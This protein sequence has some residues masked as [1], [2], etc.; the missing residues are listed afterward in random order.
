MTQVN[1]VGSIGISE[2]VCYILAP[3]VFVKDIPSLRRNGFMPV[4]WLSILSM[5]GCCLASAYNNTAIPFFL[6]G[7]AITYSLFAL[8]VCIH[9]MLRSNLDGLKWIFLGI[10]ISRIINIFVFRQ[11]Y[12]LSALAGGVEDA[13]TASMIMAGPLFWLQRLGGFIVLPVKGWYFNTPIIY[14]V[15]APLIMTVFTILTTETGR[16]ALLYSLGGVVLI[17]IGRKS[18]QKMVTIQRNLLSWGFVAVLLVFCF[19]TA[20]KQLALSGYLNEKAQQKYEHQT[21]GKSG[22]KALLMG[23]RSELFMGIYA[24]TKNPFWGFGPWNSDENGYNLEFLAKYG[25]AE[26][27]EEYSKSRALMQK[28]GYLEQ[29]QSHSHIIGFWVRY[30]MLALP[31]WLYI[32]YCMYRHCRRNM[33]AIPQWYGYFALALP[34]MAWHIVFSP[35]GGRVEDCLFIVCLLLANAVRCGTIQLPIEMISEIKRS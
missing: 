8:P 26:A 4:I 5:I 31:F 9:H 13:N 24:C 3:F 29:V 15:V 30:G 22:I 11:S 32:L 25:D 6:R 34:S 23:G 20:Y 17:M 28:Y 2:L 10:C 1:F 16:S 14:S 21:R 33:A 18:I 7:F 35:Y 27:Y 12:E 19:S